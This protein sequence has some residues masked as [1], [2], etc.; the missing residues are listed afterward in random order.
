MNK[1]IIKA[2][3]KKDI[4]SLFFSM[5]LWLPIILVPLV[6][7]IFLPV[8]II[9]L[10][11]TVNMALSG[12][13]YDIINKLLASLPNGIIK[14]EVF[15]L[16]TLNQKFVYLFLNYMFVPLFLIIPIMVSSVISAN[17]FVGEKEKK[18]LETLLF[19][20]AKELELFVAK[21]LAAFIPTMFI[22]LLS[23]ILYGVIIDTLGYSFF[24]KFIF[25]SANWLFVILWLIPALS[26]FDIFLNVYVSAK[27]KGFQEAQNISGL[28]V[29]PLLL[30]LFGQM[31]G[32]LFLSCLVIFIL[33]AVVFL[34]DIFLIKA[35]SKTFNRNELFKSQVL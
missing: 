23:F 6:F 28:V 14:A 10:G 19:S 1:K 32:V 26:I 35:V 27:V 34:I 25:P 5:E 18:T 22:S 4:H 24:N 16:P 7:V 20:P 8:L 30:L 15:S 17:S 3:I 9:I 2:I 13:N 29:L 31:F 33:G 12:T 21:I 11:K